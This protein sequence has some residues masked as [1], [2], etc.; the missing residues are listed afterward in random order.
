MR[1]NIEYQSGATVSQRA[2]IYIDVN[3]DPRAR[4]QAYLN[5]YASR[6]GAPVIAQ[7]MA[8]G[9]IYGSP[10]STAQGLSDIASASGVSKNTDRNISTGAD[11]TNAL[12]VADP[13]LDAPSNLQNSWSDAGDLTITW[14]YDTSL[15]S[16]SMASK[17]SITITSMM[18]GSIT[19]VSNSVNTSN[20]SQSYKIPYTSLLYD[21]S[22]IPQDIYSISV[23][24]QDLYGHNS[25][26]GTLTMGIMQYSVNIVAPTITVSS[27]SQGYKVSWDTVSGAS[28]ISVEEVI[29]S[30]SIDPESGYSQIYFGKVNPANIIVSDLDS[31]WVRA[32]FEISNGKYGP[33]STAYKITPTPIV[34]VNTTAP[35]EVA[36][37]SAMFSN[38]MSGNDVVVTFSL[39]MSN[40]GNSFIVKL[41]P[42][43]SPSINGY[44]YFFPSDTNSPKTF[45][46]SSKDIYAQ[47]GS[48]Y[49]SYTGLVISVSSVGVRSNGT[50]ISQFNRINSLSGITPTF[51]VSSAA[52]GYIVTWTNPSGVTYA[53]IYEKD[54]TWG[55]SD[56]TDESLRV[57]SGQSPVTIQSLHYSTRYIKIR[58]YDDY[59]NTSSYSAE[60]T[61]TPYNPGL[62]SL[63]SNPVSFQTDGSILAGDYDSVNNLPLYPNV[64]FNQTGIYAYDASGSPT[65][66]ILNVSSG[67]TFI[68]KQAQV[69]DW[70]ITEYK[71]EN[72]LGGTP[73]ENSYTGLS[74]SGSYAF[75]A[76]A[77]STSSTGPTSDTQA[78]F[79]VKKDGSVRASNISITGGSFTIGSNF[80]V[81]STG[82]LTAASANITG[83]I[84]AQ[85]G[86]FT[87]NVKLN[88]GSL[89][90]PKTSGVPSAT[91][92]GV[93]FNGSG[94]AAYN[95][96]GGVSQM[97][98]TPLADG[99]TFT[100]TA[101]NIGS[102]LIESDTIS[103]GSSGSGETGRF[104]LNA[105][106]SSNSIPYLKI[107]GTYSNALQYVQ[108]SPPKSNSYTG[109]ANVIEAGSDGV[110]PNFYVTATGIMHAADAVIKG[111]LIGNTYTSVSD[112]GN[113]HS[114]YYLDKSGDFLMG[115]DKSY[116]KY[117]GNQIILQGASYKSQV[118]SMG[119]VDAP[120]IVFSNLGKLIISNVDYIGDLGSLQV[121]GTSNSSGFIRTIASNPTTGN[122][123]RGPAIY[124]QNAG[125][126]PGNAGFVG[127]IW[128]QF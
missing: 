112:T 11:I 108:I 58:Y 103:S 52:N 62:L 24:A 9:I 82:V 16:N 107:E 40:Y 25:Q 67:N 126:G 69:A 47:F 121:P 75:W 45:T 89:Y 78:K 113:G 77:S 72:T 32:R 38:M 120:S 35:D 13:N 87:G 48:Y 43:D 79:W 71:I 23:T 6:I 42:T 50:A 116:I 91:N 21:F 37:A 12:S 127:D 80:S 55:S 20:S 76:G 2:P 57:Y 41:T 94:I 99:S 34:S 122:L 117:Y 68:T 100:T 93:V 60:Q 22:D 27:I 109:T 125:N 26:T 54:S 84:T 7:D 73:G 119:T 70:Q 97:L 118:S 1:D 59:G 105:K 114:G 5:Q 74:G 64:I 61:V 88:G 86:E 29:S 106:S 124:Y 15:S 19:Y 63:I 115:N 14:T 44:F 96:S 128:I 46:I 30:S 17:F 85:G 3:K 18:Y 81:T 65:T 111:Y 83:T 104:V 98:T 90:S 36:S 31:R 51:S 8:T 4:D 33:Y 49:S 92:A 53:D 110:G 10:S 28:N 95:G 101:A 102:W 39:P 123:E 66:E 56:P